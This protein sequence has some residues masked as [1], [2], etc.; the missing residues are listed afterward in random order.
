MS[1]AAG[2]R[3]RPAMLAV[4]GDSAA[5][6]TRSPPAWSRRWGAIAVCLCRPM[7]V[8]GSTVWKTGGTVYTPTPFEH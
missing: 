4:I 2:G 3:Q 6:K 8:N 1:R 7:I 5:G